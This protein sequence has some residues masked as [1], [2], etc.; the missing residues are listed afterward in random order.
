[1]KKNYVTPKKAGL[2]EIVGPGGDVKSFD[3]VTCFH[4]NKAWVIR[5]TEPGQSDP[6]GWCRLCMRA[7]CPVC[8]DKGCVPFETK[9]KKYEDSQKFAKEAGL[10]MN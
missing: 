1:M 10:V 9:L 4:C 2:A 7:I 6:G 5:S 3:T 8:A